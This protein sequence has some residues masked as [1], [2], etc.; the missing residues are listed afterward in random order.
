MRMEMSKI[1]SNSQ[2]QVRNLLRGCL[3]FLGII[4]FA[5]P[6]LSYAQGRTAQGNGPQ[7][8]KLA[9]PSKQEQPA[10]NKNQ[11][12][13]VKQAPVATDMPRSEF[14][15]LMDI[16][17]Q[18]R[19]LDGN[20]KATR[21]EIEEFTKRAATLKAQEQNRVLFQ[22]LDTDRNGLLSPIEFAA[23]A[24]A[25]KFI[26]V[27]AEMSRF[28]INRDQ[29]I[30]LVEYRTATLANFDRADVDKD[31]ILSSAELAKPATPPS[32][33]PSVR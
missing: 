15:R 28:D 1:Y 31:G 2:K 17:F 25:P 16:D 29:I 18:K 30:S 9:P 26:D 6:H 23:L 11:T 12:V 32:S 8:K 21:I 3:A 19:D 22:N 4:T 13:P 5:H 20:G 7:S 14:I 33:E 24:P 27:S 10:Q